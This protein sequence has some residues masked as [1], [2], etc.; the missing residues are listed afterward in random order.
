MSHLSHIPKLLKLLILLI[1]VTLLC[2]AIFLIAPL[3]SKLSLDSSSPPLNILDRNGK[4]LYEVRQSEYGSQDY[5]A[6]DSIPE[7]ALSALISIEDRSFHTHIGVRPFSV[8]RAA[9]QNYQA[10][11]VVSGGSTITQ[12]LVRNR[13]QPDR[14]DIPYKLSEMLY[15][16]KLE[17]RLSKEEILEAYLNSAYFGQQAYG[18]KSASRIFFAKQPA[19][20]SLAETSFLI[21]LL[22]SPSGY[23]PY[24]RFEL[25]KA[26][27]ERVLKAMHDTEVIGTAIYEEALDEPLTLAKRRIDIKAPHFVFWVLD[28]LNDLEGGVRQPRLQEN[29]N[30]QKFHMPEGED[31][32]PR[33]SNAQKPLST[34]QIT[35]TLDLSLQTEVE[36]IVTN[37]LA[38]LAEKNVT[39]AAVVVLD[40]K[41]GEVLSMLGSADY[42]NEENDGQVNVAVSSR[43][44]GS[45]LK[46]FTYALAMAQ[47]DTAATTIEDIEAQF[48]TQEGN[49]YIP[50]NYDYGF[51][52]L[53]RYR[54][55]LANSYN[56][57]AVKVLQKVGVAKLQEFLG[58]AGI[59]TLNQKPDFYGV[60]L[61]LGSGEVKLLEL[62]QAFGIFPRGGRTLPVS[63]LMGESSKGQIPRANQ[64]NV[65]NNQQLATNNEPS[66]ISHQ[67]SAASSLPPL[68]SSHQNTNP[69]GKQILDE[70][71]A[72]LLTSILS[73]NE[74]R[75]PEFGEASPL[76]VE[77]RPVGA[78]TGTTR[79]SR[80]NWTIGF[81]VEHLVGVWVGNADNSPMVGTSGVTG[82]GPI[83]NAVMQAASR[84][85]APKAFQQPPGLVQ[86]EVCKL[87]GLLPTEH[88]PFNISEWF[89]AGT[90][91]RQPDNLYSPARL[92][93]R[94]GLLAGSD[95]P[96]EFVTEQV[97]ID[98]P[99]ELE[100]WA[101]ENGHPD[102]PREYS[103]FCQ[104]NDQIPNPNDQGSSKG[105]VS[106]A[107]GN[108]EPQASSFKPTTS[109]QQ[110][111][112]TKP[113][114]GDAFK[115]DPL[116][117]NKNEMIILEAR[118]DS[119]IQSLTWFVDGTEIGTAKAP[120]F[121]LKWLPQVGKHKITVSDSENSDNSG[122]SKTP[123][124]WI[125]IIE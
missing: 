111:T 102:A 1:L 99:P 80:D 65:P 73:D 15:A 120:N 28:Q 64:N 55:A 115:L 33:P 77:G 4:L 43:Q 51:H 11:K 41:S 78:K 70:K 6:Y 79:N 20:L 23:D 92:D 40:I 91:P 95:C 12:Q 89:I 87:S 108:N 52:G 101:R 3:N 98:F 60:A 118:A 9:W 7:Q 42:F 44:P 34:R 104:R 29:S 62:T 24:L 124:V 114:P 94:N 83:F 84:N 90:E 123:P 58:A 45:A 110:L 61:T 46:P 82:A 113:H 88:C 30:T 75:I 122:N 10:D 35:T 117:P 5:L 39:S 96:A 48:F 93:S 22:Q 16:I 100:R 109:N 119:D 116:I 50:R 59:T 25:A 17:T 36:Q 57:P 27:Q 97:F 8:L 72:Y 105:Q 106:R 18:I 31:A 26:R 63:F 56:I 76:Y 14:R 121:R 21:G 71:I 85:R 38:K 86:K 69:S 47:G 107:N 37:Q 74:A 103:P 13:L 49:P 125:E 112:I 19:E 2:F 66:A 54:E 68:A 81:S 32:V 53:V 67:P